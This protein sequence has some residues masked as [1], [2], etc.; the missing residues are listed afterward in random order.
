M[1]K[2]SVSIG[3]D[4]FASPES[5]HVAGATYDG[6][7]HLMMITFKAR[8]GKRGSTPE[9]TYTYENIP[10]DTW[11]AFKASDSKGKFVNNAIVGQYVGHLV[12]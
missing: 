4:D 2:K 6:D 10:P 8:T 3:M 11:L 1:N 5:S 12:G 9:R 7:T